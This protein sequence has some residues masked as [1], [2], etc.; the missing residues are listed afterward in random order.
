MLSGIF[1]NNKLIDYIFLQQSH[2]RQYNRGWAFNVGY[3]LHKNADYIFCSDNDILIPNDAHMDYI[4]NYCFDYD[5]IS[6]YKNVYDTNINTNLSDYK[7][8]NMSELNKRPHTCLSGGIL[9]ISSKAFGLISGWDERFIGR[10][11]EDY[12]M[13]AKIQ[14]FIKRIHTYNVNAIHLWH[15]F[16]GNN[17]DKENNRALNEEYCSYITNDYINLIIK[18]QNQIG[19]V[20]KYTL[21]NSN[22]CSNSNCSNDDKSNSIANKLIHGFNVFDK[23][24]RNVSRHH[25][26]NCLQFVYYSLCGQHKC[27]DKCFNNCNFNNTS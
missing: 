20:N 14:L 25:D 24:L 6:P 9:G 4:W 2:D 21:N 22:C 10:G 5:A 1:A 27:H 3:K 11:W 13:T 19:N 26:S 16:E 15:P 17:V 23:V 12:A 7:K 18:T 8:I